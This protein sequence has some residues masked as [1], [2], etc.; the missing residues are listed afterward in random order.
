MRVGKCFGTD[1]T[2]K[3]VHK[4]LPEKLDPMHMQGG[5]VDLI[6]PVCKDILQHGQRE[7]VK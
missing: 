1:G 7:N 2:L 4:L 5:Q 3:G 6:G